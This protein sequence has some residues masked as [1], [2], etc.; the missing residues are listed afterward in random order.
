MTVKSA[1]KK[2]EMYIDPNGRRK[3]RMVPHDKEIVKTESG[4]K[5]I[6]TSQSSKPDRMAPGKG[7]DTF[8]PKPKKV[9]EYGGPP[10]SRDK[11]LKQKPMGEKTLTS[12]EMKKRNEV[13]KSIKRDNPDMP[14]DKKMAIA[15]S[16][17][18]K[19]VES[20][21]EYSEAY[22]NR[23]NSSLV[24]KIKKTGVVKTGSMSKGGNAYKVG[25]TVKPNK[26]PHAGQDH[27]VIHVHGD[28]S[29]NIKPKNMPASRIRYRLGAAKAKH[30]ELEEAYIDVDRGDHIGPSNVGNTHAKAEKAH[31]D[32]AAKL[33]KNHKRTDWHGGRNSVGDVIKMHK[34]AADQ[35]SK[36]LRAHN[37]GKHSQARNHA[38]KASKHG[39]DIFNAHAKSVGDAKKHSQA[40]IDAVGHSHDAEKRS[41]ASKEAQTGQR[42]SKIYEVS[43]GKLFSYM[44]KSSDDAAKAGMMNYK[45]Q[46]KRIS[47]QKKADDK[48][49]AKQGKSDAAHIKVPATENYNLD[50][51]MNILGKK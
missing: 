45:R 31:R 49:R 36:A 14:M 43:Q 12:A 20:F 28:G 48:I 26:G 6:A 9:D 29:Y 7:L 39:T 15:T 35:H 4:M 5:R 19:A 23:R 34:N 33:K 37:A 21:K 2:P 22:M 1:D 24:N 3:V 11:Y 42:E 8:K 17:A 18:K 41:K 40:G 44:K 32:M 51:L 50:T 30:S 10:I 38:N 25:Q 27:E 47:G 13:A 16:V 46:D